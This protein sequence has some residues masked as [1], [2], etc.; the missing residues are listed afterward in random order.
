MIHGCNSSRSSG[1]KKGDKRRRQKKETKKQDKGEP[2][3]NK[4][5]MRYVKLV[6]TKHA[7]EIRRCL[8]RGACRCRFRLEG[9]REKKKKKEARDKN[10]EGLRD[11]GIERNMKSMKNQA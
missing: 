2:E 7:Y 9:K 11:D 10:E 4:N 6:I 3:K 8:L 5:V 1:D